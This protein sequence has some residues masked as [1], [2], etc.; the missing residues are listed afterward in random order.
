MNFWLQRVL[1]GLI[2][3]SAAASA[4][5]CQTT[6]IRPARVADILVNPGMGIQT[7]QRYNGDSL[8]SGTEWSEE[9]PTGVLKTGASDFPKSTIAYCRWFWSAI[10]PAKGQVKWEILDRALAE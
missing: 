4:G 9:G 8:N 6:V 7:F 10:E 1:A 2:L 3:A 5:W